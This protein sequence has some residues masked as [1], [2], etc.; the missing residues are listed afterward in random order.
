MYYLFKKA[1]NNTVPECDY[2]FKKFSDFY[3]IA[4]LLKIPIIGNYN[5][6]IRSDSYNDIMEFV[7]ISGSYNH[8]VIYVEVNESLLEYITLHK[9]TISLLGSKSNYEVFKE[10]VSKY[11]ILFDKGCIKTLYFA[12]GHSY[13]E[14]DEALE[15]VHRT[16]AD[17]KL[18]T[19]DDLTKLFVIDE[20]TYP[21]SVLIAYLRLDY[22]RQFK[23]KRCVNHFGNDLVF[24][25]MR[26]TCRNFLREKI[27]YLKTGKGNG[28]IKTIPA[29]NIVR[30]LNVLE[31]SNS[32]FK[33]VQTLLYLYERG[34]TI[35][36]TL[37]KGTLSFTDEKYYAS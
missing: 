36:D 26:K 13:E 24:Y 22:G 4:K 35:N 32:G 31:Y 25:S 8:L 33:D 29:E 18:V 10:L 9:P 15:L 34:E 5:I 27:E 6:L 14:M 2:V 19:R 30:M 20:L 12:I 16:Y 1:K 23:L 17:K 3:E 11:G 21:R 28:L 37:Q 7:E